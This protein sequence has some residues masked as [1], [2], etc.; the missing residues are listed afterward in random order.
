MVKRAKSFTFLKCIVFGVF[1]WS[2][3]DKFHYKNYQVLK[4]QNIS[5][6]AIFLKTKLQKSHLG[7]G[8]PIYHNTYFDELFRY[9]LKSERKKIKN[10]GDV[11]NVV[12]NYTVFSF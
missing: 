3:L 8:N 9:E 12:A 11:N 5:K 7:E 6:S 10:F 2:C 1:L 4:T